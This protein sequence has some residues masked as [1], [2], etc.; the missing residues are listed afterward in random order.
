MRGPFLPATG[1]VVVSA[2]LDELEHAVVA[3]EQAAIHASSE[4]RRLRD[5]QA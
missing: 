4:I 2:S 3:V 1:M 5:Q